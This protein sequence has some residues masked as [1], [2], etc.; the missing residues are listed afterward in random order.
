MK[1]IIGLLLTLF[2]VFSACNTW[3][4][5]NDDVQIKSEIEKLGILDTGLFEKESI[6]TRNDC[7]ALIMKAI[8]MPENVY[9]NTYN[10][11]SPVFS[12][13][14]DCSVFD[15]Y[16]KEMEIFEKCKFTKGNYVWAAA[17]YANIVF[18]ESRDNGRIYFNFTRPVTTKEAVAFMVRCLKNPDM[19]LTGLDQTFQRGIELGLIKTTD[20]CYLESDNPILPNDFFTIL[21]RFLQQPVYLYYDGE[22]MKDFHY[23][24]DENERYYTFLMSRKQR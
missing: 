4:V 23:A 7:V 16:D 12:D 10:S 22:Q 8:G 20:V 1:R 24:I 6:L 2:I 21:Y 5:A 19:D 9:N 13:Y 18:G 3:V 14:T 15:V 11:P 17:K